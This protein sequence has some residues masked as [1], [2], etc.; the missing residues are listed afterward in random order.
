MDRLG[1]HLFD[2]KQGPTTQLFKTKKRIFDFEEKKKFYSNEKI[3]FFNNFVII[4]KKLSKKSA[5]IFQMKFK[6]RKRVGSKLR[7]IRRRRAAAS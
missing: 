2:H 4:L 7:I 1:P 3:A 5:Q 6:R